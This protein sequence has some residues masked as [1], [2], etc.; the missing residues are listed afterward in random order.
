MR[1]VQYKINYVYI[2]SKVMK[3]YSNLFDRYDWRSRV[4]LKK[5]WYFKLHD[6]NNEE[7]Q[8]ICRKKKIGT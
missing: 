2:F 5:F 8:I 4:T 1:D 3:N 6:L 7:L